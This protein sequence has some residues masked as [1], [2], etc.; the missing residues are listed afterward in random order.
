MITTSGARLSSWNGSYS[1]VRHWN[2]SMHWD[3][4]DNY[5][6]MWLNLRKP[7]RPVDYIYM[8]QRLYIYYILS[9]KY[10]V[11]KSLISRFLCRYHFI[12]TSRLCTW[13][14]R[15]LWF[16]VK[17]DKM[18]YKFIGWFLCIWQVISWNYIILLANCNVRHH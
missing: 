6:I 9:L 7:G 5:I 18:W 2:T 13:F 1:P 8:W 14:V 17:M 16:L 10:F 3:I 4:K 11:V 12:S 15:A